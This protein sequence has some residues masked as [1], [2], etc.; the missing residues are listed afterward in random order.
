M[1]TS[2][3]IQPTRLLAQSPSTP[4]H[5]PSSRMDAAALDCLVRQLKRSPK[6]SSRLS[7]P[8]IMGIIP[9]E[10]NEEDPV[11]Q[12]EEGEAGQVSVSVVEVKGRI[13][14]PGPNSYRLPRRASMIN[15]TE[16]WDIPEGDEEDE[17]YG[18]AGVYK[19]HA[20]SELENP[21]SPRRLAMSPLI[22]AAVLE[23][24]GDTAT[25]CALAVDEKRQRP[26]LLHTTRPETAGH[27][28]TDTPL[29]ST[30]TPASL[31]VPATDAS[32][33]PDLSTASYPHQ[34]RRRKS[35]S[36][37]EQYRK[38]A[39]MR[40]AFAISARIEAEAERLRAE[41]RL[42]ALQREGLWLST[43]RKEIAACAKRDMTSTHPPLSV[44][45]PSPLSQSWPVVTT[46]RGSQAECS[47]TT[48]D[49]FDM[50]DELEVQHLEFAPHPGSSPLSA[51][52]DESPTLS[53]TSSLASPP[54]DEIGTPLVPSLDDPAWHDLEIDANQGG[55]S[56]SATDIYARSAVHGSSVAGDHYLQQSA[57]A[58]LGLGLL[59]IG[60]GEMRLQDNKDQGRPFHGHDGQDQAY[61][62]GNHAPDFWASSPPT[63]YGQEA[64][65]RLMIPGQAIL[66]IQ[67]RECE[68]GSPSEGWDPLSVKGH[69]QAAPS[70]M[71]TYTGGVQPIGIECATDSP[72]QNGHRERS[73]SSP[74]L[75]LL[76]L[77]EEANATVQDSRYERSSRRPSTATATGDIAGRARSRSAPATDRRVAGS[78]RSQ[79]RIQA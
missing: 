73:I 71:T 37:C 2:L 9:E 21:F 4:Y 39:L 16:L 49:W 64:P 5:P 26:P 50:D 11:G 13:S 20:P 27:C 1:S 12:K 65:K 69:S 56:A 53:P 19:A 48:T 58:G 32:V 15:L 55:L 36:E 8:P 34:R 18:S 33:Q 77:S 28:S 47:M 74:S 6:S 60:E 54:A 79:S 52:A 63:M 10:L 43:R 23:E 45:I 76:S 30:S 75:Q 3:A 68:Y 59:G 17:G 29:D 67:N 42:A 31:F 46:S 78:H 41:E 70:V 25:E 66:D 22:H 7:L 14:P 38:W 44:S 51:A 24:A 57:N 35:L 62:T 61:P 40:C 72:P